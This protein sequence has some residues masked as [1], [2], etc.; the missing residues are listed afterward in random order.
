MLPTTHL[1]VAPVHP[2]EPRADQE[3]TRKQ[4]TGSYV[5]CISLHTYYTVLYCKCVSNTNS[6]GYTIYMYVPLTVIAICI[7]VSL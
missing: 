3:T 2:V 6:D 1:Y 5:L 4:K 7:A